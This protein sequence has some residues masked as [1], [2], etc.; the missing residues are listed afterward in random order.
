GQNLSN[1]FGPLCPLCPLWW[2]ASGGCRGIRLSRQADRLRPSRHRRSRDDRAAPDAGGIDDR[3]GAAVADPG[4]R[5][6]S[7]LVQPRPV[8]EHAPERA[9]LVFTIEPGP[10]AAIGQIDVAGVPAASRA[11]LLARLG[12][13][14][15]A[16]YQ[17]DALSARI[18]KYIGERRSKGYYEAK[19]EPV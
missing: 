7:A 1:A 12:I 5:N 10:R 4:A 9:T 19:I 8:L 18:E 16:P 3:G 11:E 6:G 13:A 15:G 2:S 14:P 17:R